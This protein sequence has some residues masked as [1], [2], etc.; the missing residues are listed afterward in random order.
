LA[1]ST[2]PRLTLSPDAIDQLRRQ[3]SGRVLLAGDDGYDTARTVW[4]A[5][6][7]RSPTLIVQP[8]STQDVVAAVQFANDQDLPI[9]VRGGG[10]S[11][12]GLAVCDDGLMIDLSAMRAVEV[13]PAQRTARAQ[14]GARWS[15]FDAATQAHGLATTGG[16]ISTTGIAGL[17]LGGGLG[18]LMR[19]YGLASDNLISV[20][21]VT[22]NGE[23]VTASA[24]E[25]PDLFWGLHGVGGNFG[26]ATMLE[27]QLHPVDQV[28]GGMLLFPVE[29]A[30][31]LLR[32]YRKVTATAPDALATSAALLFTPDGTPVC[33]L[34]ICY[35]GPIADGE[36][37]IVPYREFG[38]P[39][40]DAVGPMP[41]TAIQ[42][43]LDDGFGPGFHSYW[44]AHFL[45][46]LNEGGI[47]TLVD[48]FSRAASPLSLV[49]IE[50]L[51]GAVGRVGRDETAYDHRDYEYNVA[52]IGRWAEPTQ[53]DPN[54][55]WTRAL[56]DALQPYAAG[57]YVNYLGAEEQADRLRAAYG[58]KKYA[59]LV[60]LKNRYD[61]TNRFPFNQ[62][63]KPA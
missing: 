36:R 18:S 49:L 10:H 13:D 30:P 22:A 17:T 25:N 11:A 55:A 57:V 44:R 42:S 23:V 53:A 3:I 56:S 26:V 60:E 34:V 45:T 47:A 40:V 21:L 51:G 54:I 41:Y 20:E 28:L 4:N 32:L 37:A 61:P 15:D 38:T 16:A 14:G 29:R 31:E 43:M 48:H 8:A 59:R 5:M 9:A 19:S 58:D 27:Y 46:D 7:D 1:I 33:G 52:I 50:H 24:T 12:A 62:N 35:N 63:I 2:T 6:I 39:I